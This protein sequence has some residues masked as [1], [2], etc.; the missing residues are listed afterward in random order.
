MQ[1]TSKDQ[2]LSDFALATR[3][4]DRNEAL[5]KCRIDAIMLTCLAAQ[6]RESSHQT[7]SSSL[8]MHLQLETG[9]RFPW[10]WDGKRKAITGI[11]I[12][13][14]WYATPGEMESNLLI[15]E[16]QSEGMSGD[17]QALAYMGKYACPEYLYVYSPIKGMIYHARRK[18]QRKDVSMF[19]IATDSCAW[20]FLHIDNN[21][22]VR[23]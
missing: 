14:L 9:I 3:G 22:K 19:G 1:L 23:S 12:Y 7:R 17:Y 4:S 16:A 11:T 15:V 20:T 13:S 2:I 8:P 21:G 10:T 18:A 6:K 5:M